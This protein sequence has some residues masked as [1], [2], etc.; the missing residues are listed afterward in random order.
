[1]ATLGFALPDSL[2]FGF[3]TVEIQIQH[4][5]GRFVTDVTGRRCG[6]RGD[7]AKYRGDHYCAG[8]L[9]GKFW[10]L[11]CYSDGIGQLIEASVVVLTE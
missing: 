3:M 4:I 10:I 2:S 9:L 1:M 5:T 6:T 11:L 7:A 8:H